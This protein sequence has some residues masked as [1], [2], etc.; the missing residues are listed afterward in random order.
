MGIPPGGAA[1]IRRLDVRG[2]LVGTALLGVLAIGAGPSPVAAQPRERLTVATEVSVAGRYTWRGVTR[3]DGPA[4]QL[5][6]LAVWD[7]GFAAFSVTG[8]TS[9]ASG[10]CPDSVVSCPVPRDV[11]VA[12][13]NVAAAVTRS[14]GGV[15]LSA[16]VA[17]YQFRPA[18][19]DALEGRSDTWEARVGLSSRPSHHLQWELAAWWD[20]DEVGGLYYEGALTVPF[21]PWSGRR[22]WSFF[23]AIVGLS[24]GQAARPG[25]RGYFDRNDFVFA[26]LQANSVLRSPPEG[27]SGPVLQAFLGVQGN[28]DRNTRRASPWRDR[29]REQRVLVGLVLRSRA[30]L[31]RRP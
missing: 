20:L 4:G 21:H 14:L 9:I 26:T 11:R 7:P 29:E 28:F 1:V 12:D 30:V 25:E 13:L 3:H 19:W 15:L 2:A 16:G 31:S 6:A 5:A 18:P 10:G 24:A 22:R 8:W 17:R 27:R 23:T